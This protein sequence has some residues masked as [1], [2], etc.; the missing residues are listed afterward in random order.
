[1][2]K[3]VEKLRKYGYMEDDVKA[4]S[5]EIVQ[6]RRVEKGS[7][8]DIFYVEEGYLPNTRNG[9]TEES[10]L[11][12]EEVFGRSNG[13]EEIGFPWEKIS[14]KVKKELESEWT[15]KKENRYSLAEITLPEYELRRLRNL[16]FKTASK[17]KIRGAGVTQVA[18]DSIKEK[19]KKLG[20][21]EENGKK[22]E[23]TET[24]VVNNIDEQV[25]LSSTR[26]RDNKCRKQSQEE[27]E[28]KDEIDKLFDGIG[29]RF[30]D[31]P[32]DN[33]LPV[34]ADLLQGAILS[35]EPPFRVLPYGVRSSLGP[36]E[37]T[38]FKK[39]C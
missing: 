26:P 9:F 17:M 32:G 21:C 34:D 30:I 35:Y 11:Y 36:K 5:K 1:M 10:V 15:A 4:L 29:P 13:E 27:V 38:A 20:D 18:V 8:Q 31:W 2:E 12:R 25:D 33:P 28:Y 6:E 22:R 7:V 19:W 16:N 39:T 24:T 3:I 14:A 23:E 37:A